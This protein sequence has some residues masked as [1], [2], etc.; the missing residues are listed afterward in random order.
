MTQVSLVDRAIPLIDNL[1]LSWKT[2]IKGMRN[3]KPAVTTIDIN[4][5]VEA[6]ISDGANER[7]VSQVELI[8]TLFQNDLMLINS[9]NYK[10]L[11]N[12]GK[13]VW[14]KYHENTG[15]R[16]EERRVGKEC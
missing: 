2:F 12:V 7:K 13:D 11:P 9:S 4:A 10:E 8:D 16:S 15:A 6:V 3:Y 5:L 14:F 1:M